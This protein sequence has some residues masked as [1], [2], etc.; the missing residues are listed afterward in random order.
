MPI[1]STLR[2]LMAW[3]FSTRASVTSVLSTHSCVSSCRWVKVLSHIHR[4]GGKMASAQIIRC[5]HSYAVTERR[6]SGSKIRSPK[7]VQ[8]PPNFSASTS[9]LHAPNHFC[10]YQHGRSTDQPTTYVWANHACASQPRMCEHTHEGAGMSKSTISTPLPLCMCV[11][12]PLGVDRKWKYIFI[13]P[14]MN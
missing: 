4:L 8:H 11:N 2:T 5:V 1:L 10:P 9:K 14:K 12:V 7:M 13:F 3:Y 6:R